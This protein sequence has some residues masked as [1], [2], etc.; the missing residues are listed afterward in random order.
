MMT[1]QTIQ[2][3][4]RIQK[5]KTSESL[6]NKHSIPKRIEPHFFVDCFLVKL[7]QFFPAGECRYKHQEACPGKM[8]VRDHMIDEMQRGGF[9][10]EEGGGTGQFLE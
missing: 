4:Q 8:E 2:K 7:H 9:G 1:I 6:Y 3:I 5:K 10:E